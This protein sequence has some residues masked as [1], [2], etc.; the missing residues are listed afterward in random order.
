MQIFEI[1]PTKKY[2]LI[3]ELNLSPAEVERMRE[4]F[5]QFMKNHEAHFLVIE[6]VRL[7]K[8][9]DVFPGGDGVVLGTDEG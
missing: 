3:F 6:G 5:S 7:V 1:N 8:V 9:D 2:A 4:L